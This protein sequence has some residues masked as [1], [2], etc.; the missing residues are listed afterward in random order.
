[1]DLIIQPCL[2]GPFILPS[3]YELASPVYA[4]ETSEPGVLQKPCRVQI[5]HYARLMSEK[6]CEGMIFITAKIN[7]KTEWF[8]PYD[9]KAIKGSFTPNTQVG[10]TRLS[11]FCC[12]GCAMP[13]K[14]SAM[15]YI[16]K[17]YHATCTGCGSST[18]YSAR[19][20]RGWS[21]DHPSHPSPMAVFC[22][23]LDHPIY[24]RVSHCSLASM[25]S[26]SIMLIIV[27]PLLLSSLLPP[28]QHCEQNI[29][30]KYSC[31][32]Q[33]EESIFQANLRRG[34]EEVELS[35]TDCGGWDVEYDREPTKVSLYCMCV[36]LRVSLL[37]AL[38]PSVLLKM[39]YYIIP[40]GVI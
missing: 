36:S 40:Q 38:H 25:L 18:N 34:V 35:V 7:P 12:L 1:V 3:G 24:T 31:I 19:L 26:C 8:G 27:L 9:F 4:I 15:A 32:L 13:S 2:N 10:E 22:M 21:Q 20:Y 11:H 23:S 39:G 37:W 17:I 6:D 28:L 5:Q 16:F 14:Y 33:G 29:Q 30:Q